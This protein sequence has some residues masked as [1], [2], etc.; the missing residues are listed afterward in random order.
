M[1][2]LVINGPAALEIRLPFYPQERTFESI[3]Y[4]NDRF[5]PKVAIPASSIFGRFETCRPAGTMSVPGGKTGSRRPA[6][7]LTRLT[8]MRHGWKNQHANILSSFGTICISWISRPTVEWKDT[9][10]GVM[11]DGVPVAGYR[12]CRGRILVM[13]IAAGAIFRQ[14]ETNLHTLLV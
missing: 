4:V 9:D 3:I 11:G 13:M 2:A 8:L 5:A 6:V 12:L 7:E 10:C 14:P 1:S